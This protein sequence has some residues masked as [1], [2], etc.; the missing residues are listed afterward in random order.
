MKPIDCLLKALVLASSLGIAASGLA[1]DTT[2]VPPSK[3]AVATKN[4]PPASGT[5]APAK[6]EEEPK[7]PGF[8]IPRENGGYLGLTLENYNFR[9]SFYNAKK[10]QVAADVIRA[11]ARWPVHY[12][13]L[14]ERTVLN[15]TPDGMALISNQFVRPPYVFKLFLTLFAKS[16]EEETAVEH[17]VVDF[18]M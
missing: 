17:Y 7:I 12:K 14:E 6:V 10:K 15:L 16:G 3:S 4:A 9:L 2:T 5:K 13:A 18:R 11:R 8:V 1:Q